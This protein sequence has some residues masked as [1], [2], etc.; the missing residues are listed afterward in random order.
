MLRFVLIASLFAVIVF[1]MVGEKVPVND[2]TMGDGLFYRSIA[3]D[4]LGK[5]EDESYNVF[6]LQRVMPF[7]VLNV[8]FSLFEWVKSHEGLLRGIVILNFLMAALGVY[9]Y[10]ALTR[11]LR[12]RDNLTVLGF[13]LLFVNF[14]VLK[15][16]WYHPFHPGFSAMMLGIGQVNYF[17]R[18]ERQRLFLLSLV[19]GFVWP[20]MFLTGLFLMLM[21]SDKLLVHESDRPKSFYP[22]IVCCIVLVVLIIT[23]IWT[24]RFGNGGGELALHILS[25]AALLIYFLAFLIKNP[26]QWKR[27]FDLFRSK[28]KAGKLQVFWLS[29]TAFFLIIFLLSGSNGNIF[30]LDVAENYFTEILRFPLDFLVGH[31]LYF[32]FLVPLAMVFFPRMMKEM[33]NLGMGFAMACTFMFVFILHPEPQFLLPFYPFLVLLIL[34]SVKRYRLLKKDILVI[35]GFNLL[36][37][38]AWLPLNVSGME[39]ALG[40]ENLSLLSQ[41]PAQRYWMHFGHMMSWE[42]YIGAAVVFTL[43]VWLAWNGKIRY[44]REAKLGEDAEASRTETGHV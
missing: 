32:G 39:E 22:I 28:L 29:L 6:Q 37:S 34:K 1:Q 30:F 20:S 9:W 3:E 12:L 21:P 19:S 35:G 23:G 15:D 8:T 25:I 2:G 16:M 14:A 11:K 18:V 17:V 27:S 5:I 36:L 31:T 24:G 44:K 26:I 13:L 4:F 41:F 40:G 7:A 43:L 38:A 33:A 10:F 42:V